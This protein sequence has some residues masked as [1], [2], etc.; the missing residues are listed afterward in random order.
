MTNNIEGDNFKLSRE[1]LIATRPPV[2]EHSKGNRPQALRELT[3]VKK[4]KFFE[5][6]ESDSFA[7]A[8]S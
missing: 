5:Y 4:D 2:V 8:Q 6:G 1:V 3:K 7:L